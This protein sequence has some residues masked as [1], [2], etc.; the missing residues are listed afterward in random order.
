MKKLSGLIVGVALAGVTP[1][2]LADAD[3]Y[4]LMPQ[5]G[6]AETT[7]VVRADENKG[8]NADANTNAFWYAGTS[9]VSPN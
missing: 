8:I 7:F 1:F 2:A 9:G 4:Y 3:P 5:V 6:G